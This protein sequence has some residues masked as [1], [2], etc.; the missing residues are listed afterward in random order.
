MQLRECRKL[1]NRRQSLSSNR[2][3]V[4]TE[5]AELRQRCQLL[6]PGTADGC[7][8]QMKRSELRQLREMSKPGIRHL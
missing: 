3:A 7:L 4:Q 6:K 8:V 2:R 5:F 1:T